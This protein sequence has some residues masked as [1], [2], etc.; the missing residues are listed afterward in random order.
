MVLS[1]QSAHEGNRSAMDFARD[2]KKEMGI[3]GFFRGMEARFVH[4]GLIVT[5][6]LLIYD[7]IKRVVGIVATGSA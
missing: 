4:V 7:I 3:K 2:I 6:Q 5:V 1:V